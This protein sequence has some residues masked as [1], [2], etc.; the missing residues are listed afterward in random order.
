MAIDFYMN[1]ISICIS[2]WEYKKINSRGVSGEPEDIVKL[3]IGG[4]KKQQNETLHCCH[5]CRGWHF[6]SETKQSLNKTQYPATPCG[7][8]RVQGGS[9]ADRL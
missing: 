4:L 2:F 8:A 6:A 1:Y 7:W 5:C 3:L 9:G